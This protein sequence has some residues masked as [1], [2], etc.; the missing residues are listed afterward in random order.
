MISKKMNEFIE[1][2][3]SL[4]WEYGYQIWPTDKINKR[5]D[6]GSYLTFTIHGDGEKVSL[7]YIDGDGRGK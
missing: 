6:D 1:K 3:D 7:I 4:C 5:N 2:V